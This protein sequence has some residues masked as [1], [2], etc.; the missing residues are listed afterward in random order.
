VPV[1]VIDI[2]VIAITMGKASG[3]RAKH[4]AR[5]KPFQKPHTQLNLKKEN[6]HHTRNPHTFKSQCLIEFFFKKKTLD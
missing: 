1:N 2:E 6:T 4:L 3:T 5:H